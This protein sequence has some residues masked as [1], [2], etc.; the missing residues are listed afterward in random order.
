V[1][2]ALTGLV[3]ATHP[4]PTALV[5]AISVLVAVWSGRDAA[6]VVLVAATVVSG[7][8]GVGWL[9]D[10]LDRERDARVGRR[11]KPLVAGT[12]SAPMLRVAIVVSVP[13]C[14][15]LSLLNGIAAGLAHLLA[16]ASAWSYDLGLKATVLSPAP[17]ALSFGLLPVF[18]ALGLPGRPPTA[19]WVVATGAL[20]G[21]SAHFLNC[22]PDLAGDRRTGILGLPQ[23]LGRRGSL[24]AAGVCVGASL[25]VVVV[26]V[27]TGTAAHGVSG[28]TAL[29][30][31]W[32]R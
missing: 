28:E 22:V 29:A 30:S 13:V 24:A 32:P 6:G 11:D 19:A 9:N 25:V 5:V 23:R 16:V 20:L 1:V 2:A 17:Y 21:V 4:G 3:R 27:V 10:L 7:Q 31:L 26:A 8:V 14:V 12:V 15:L 18:V